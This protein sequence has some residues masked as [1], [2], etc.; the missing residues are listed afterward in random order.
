MGRTTTTRRG[1]KQAALPDLPA[2]DGGE[3]SSTTT[4]RQGGRRAVLDGERGGRRSRP[5]FLRL[6][7]EFASFGCVFL[8][9]CVTQT[10][11]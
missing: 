10:V 11:K 6:L 7:L 9:L 1:G 5:L 2:D 8:S 4:V 3:A